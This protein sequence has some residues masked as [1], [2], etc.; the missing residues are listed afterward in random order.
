MVT[1]RARTVRENF[2]VLE[3][4]KLRRVGLVYNRGTSEA[5]LFNSSSDKSEI[6]LSGQI[7]D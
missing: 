5:M 6:L 3:D 2:D 1:L 4:F 7:R